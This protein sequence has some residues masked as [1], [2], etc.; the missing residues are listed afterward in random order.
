MYLVPNEQGGR[1]PDKRI[2]D[3]AAYTPLP[4]HDV[5][6]F[7]ALGEQMEVALIWDP[8]NLGRADPHETKAW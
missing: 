5:S 8:L 1:A 6:T 3:W 4:E 2:V 7:M